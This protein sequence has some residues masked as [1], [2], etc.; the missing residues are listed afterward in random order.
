[1]LGRYFY[2]SDIDTKV[3]NFHRTLVLICDKYF[4]QKKI[5]ISNL[6]KKWITPEL[7]TLSRKIKGEFYRNGK[8]SKWKKLKKE[9]KVKKKRAIQSFHSIF[10]TDLNQTNPGKFYKMCRKIGTG[11]EMTSEIKI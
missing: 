6:D 7:K 3:Y 11:D 8:S 4:P 9:F 2:E 10:V 5:T 1:M